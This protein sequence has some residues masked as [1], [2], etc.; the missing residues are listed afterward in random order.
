MDVAISKRFRFLN[1]DDWTD[2]EDNCIDDVVDCDNDDDDD[3]INSGQE[4]T[5]IVHAEGTFGGENG[6]E[7]SATATPYPHTE[8]FPCEACI[9]CEEVFMHLDC[10]IV[11]R[12]WTAT[13]GEDTAITKLT[14]MSSRVNDG[15]VSFVVSLYARYHRIVLPKAPAVDAD[16]ISHIAIRAH[17]VDTEVKMAYQRS[18]QE[19]S[20]DEA[21]IFIL[22]QARNCCITIL[23]SAISWTRQF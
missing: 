12:I 8:S 14:T 1:C 19:K 23:D 18:M 4:T 21:A 16:Q 17:R 10:P 3:N 7:T 2:V 22:E 15:W 20:Y 13:A 9:L 5:W 6:L 11:V